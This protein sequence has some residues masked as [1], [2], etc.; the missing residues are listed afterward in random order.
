MA[1]LLPAPDDTVPP[2]PPTPPP[3]PPPPIVTLDVV[4]FPNG[5]RTD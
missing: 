4:I 2:P 5:L 3:P 1:V